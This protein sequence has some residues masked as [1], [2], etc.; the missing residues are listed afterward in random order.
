MKVIPDANTRYSALQAG[1]ILGVFDLGAIQPLQAKELCKDER[2]DAFP[3]RRN[4]GAYL[5]LNGS[6]ISI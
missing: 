2:F 6:R 5:Y 3:V 4:V 1:E